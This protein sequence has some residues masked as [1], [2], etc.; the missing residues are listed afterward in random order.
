MEAAYNMSKQTKIYH[1]VV[2]L[3]IAG[4]LRV[5][6]CEQRFFC[7][8]SNSCLRPLSFST[9]QESLPSGKNNI[10]VMNKPN[11]SDRRSVLAL[12]RVI[13]GAP[14]EHRL[15]ASVSLIASAKAAL[16]K[17]GL[18]AVP[19]LVD[20]LKKEQRG[21]HA[22]KDFDLP[23]VTYMANSIMQIL[24]DIGADARPLAAPVLMDYILRYSSPEAMQAVAKIGLSPEQVREITPAL[25]R[26]TRLY[27]D[28]KYRIH[29]YNNDYAA[30]R[31]TA[32]ETLGQLRGMMAIG[33]VAPA[34]MLQR[35]I[36]IDS[37]I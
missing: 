28:E 24:G 17:M 10:D 21:S 16:V 14:M 26:V 2:C 6:N 19:T 33:A 29:V 34:G 37:A 32:V 12:L 23:S 3:I 27:T 18:K 11:A 15:E 30:V 20:V 7:A 25:I 8:Y 22:P 1:L 4:F 35:G 5:E 9:R 13:S 31:Q 36:E